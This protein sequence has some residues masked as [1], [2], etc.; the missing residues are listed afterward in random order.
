V[1]PSSSKKAT[2]L[3]PIDIGPE[4]GTSS[5]FGAELS[6]LLSIELIP[7]TGPLFDW[8]QLSEKPFYLR[9]ETHFSL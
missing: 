2:R 3:N 4:L 8:A 1:H 5:I 7:I 9:M 6:R